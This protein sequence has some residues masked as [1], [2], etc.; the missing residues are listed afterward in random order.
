MR[1]LKALLGL[2][3]LHLSS[4]LIGSMAIVERINWLDMG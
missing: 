1:K 3:Q 2:R 4:H